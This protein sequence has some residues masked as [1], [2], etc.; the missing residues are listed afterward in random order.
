MNYYFISWDGI[1]PKVEMTPVIKTEDGYRIGE[2]GGLI[3]HGQCDGIPD[4]DRAAIMYAKS[5]LEFERSNSSQRNNEFCD[6]KFNAL[7]EM[8]KKLV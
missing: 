6:K 5:R 8:D 7:L 3:I 4:N 2:N 1:I